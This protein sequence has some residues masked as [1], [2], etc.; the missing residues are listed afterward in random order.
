M[1]N[2]T[3]LRALIVS[4]TPTWPLNYG[5]RKRIFSVC[6][7]LKQRGFEVHF[8]HYVSEMDWNNHIPIVSRQK[9]NEQW[10]I[11]DHVMKSNSAVHQWPQSGKDHLIDEW[12]DEALQNHLSKTFQAREYDLLIVNYTWLSMA[13]EVAPS[14]TLKLLDTHDVFSGRRHLL[15][16]NNIHKEFFHTTEEQELIA[17]NRADIVW[18][19]K[20][21]EQVFF[22]SLGTKAKVETL[23]H[24]DQ[25]RQSP[26]PV[27][28]TIVHFGFVSA[29]NNINRVNLT[30]FI[31]EA[32]PVFEKYMPPLQFFIAGSICS[33]LD[34]I[35]SP[36]IKK[37]GYLESIDEF[38]D[39]LHCA[40]IPMEFSTG[41]KIK[42]AEAFSHLKP[43]ISHQHAMEGFPAQHKYHECKSF[44]DMA[45]AMCE[46]AFEK[47]ELVFMQNASIKAYDIISKQITQTFDSLVGTIFSRKQ[48]VAILP[49]EYGDEQSLMHWLVKSRLDWISWSYPHIIKVKLGKSEAFGIFNSDVRM[50]T[51]EKLN[52]LIVRTE[53]DLIINLCWDLPPD[54]KIGS[55]SCVSFR[56][57][58]DD[59]ASNVN[60]PRYYSDINDPNYLPMLGHINPPM[61]NQASMKLKDEIWVI[62]GDLSS[63]QKVLLAN[64][65]ALSEINYLDLESIEELERFIKKNGLPYRIILGRLPQNL[66][67]VEQLMVDIALKYNLQVIDLNQPMIFD[68]SEFKYTTRNY[69]DERFFD[70]WERFKSFNLNRHNILN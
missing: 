14:K 62:G 40:V 59:V 51:V 32:E 11:V 17:L 45:L 6:N 19:I 46:I 16:S 13:L 15:E 60:V 7:E 33:M 47:N 8:V 28:N 1:S 61:L 56:A 41:L 44:E 18:A 26:Q 9:M 53:P 65:A 48:V 27:S 55:F 52:Q 58:P 67:V 24:I 5:N 38:Y 68:F 4:P 21:D 39:N 69:Y 2:E 10:D 43:V 29:N 49:P 54:L 50:L 63:A 70:L 64:V 36:F 20:E 12:W 30:R 42:V 25:S 22:E 31:E 66:N 23:L 57:L 37:L 3:I 34:N 35:D